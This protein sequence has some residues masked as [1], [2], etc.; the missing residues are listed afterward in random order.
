MSTRQA[1]LRRLATGPAPFQQ[2]A[3]APVAEPSDLHRQVQRLQKLASLG[4]QSAILAHEFNNLLTPLIGHAQHA[5]ERRDPNELAA[6]LEKTLAHARRA[7]A[8][9]E[10]LLGLAADDRS[11]PESTGLLSLVLDTLDCLVRDLARD[12][13]EVAVRIDERLHAYIHAPSIQQVLFNL[14]VNARQAMLGRRG[15]L[16]ISARPAE[17]G[18]V[19]LSVADTGPGIPADVLPYVFEPFFTTRAVDGP[20]DRRGSGLGLAI[21]RQLVEENG[22]ALLVES[23]DGHGATFTITLPAA[24]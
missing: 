13:I 12:G 14:L 20:L 9:C 19:A 24:D 7:A 21:S 5:L 6:A 11:A 10:K 16:T 3:G 23:R 2:G 17:H 22:G 18:F 15:R 4:T 1:T 8:L